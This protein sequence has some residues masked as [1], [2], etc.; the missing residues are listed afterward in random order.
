VGPA[1]AWDSLAIGT[2]Y[3]VPDGDGLLMYYV[4]FGPRPTARGVGGSIGLA[5]SDGRD[6]TRWDKVVA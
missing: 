1:G 3:L 6:L 4:G 5:R 2:P